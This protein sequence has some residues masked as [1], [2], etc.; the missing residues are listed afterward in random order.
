[1]AANEETHA[2]ETH[3][4][5]LDRTL[6]EMNDKMGTMAELIGKLCSSRDA[7]TQANGQD[8]PA[9]DTD[10]HN[11]RR[12]RRRRSPSFSSS[13]S[14]GQPDDVLSSVD[15]SEDELEALIQDKTSAK[16]DKS[17]HGATASATEGLLDELDAVL[18]E[19]DKLGPKVHEKLAGIILKRWGKKLPQEKITSL[20]SQHVVPENCSREQMK[21]ALKRE[22]PHTLCNKEVDEPSKLLFGEDLAKQIRDAKETTK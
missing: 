10:R 2:R 21:P 7:R 22:L 15:A 11:S 4:D 19:E 14:D 6:G 13:S 20:L 12:K 18:A 16:D 8:S 1:M 17:Q 3:A 5:R 9:G